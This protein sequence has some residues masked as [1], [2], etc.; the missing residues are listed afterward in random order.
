[1]GLQAAKRAEEW[2]T[3]RECA[4]KY[5]ALHKP[6]W[7]NP[8]HAE[9]WTSTLTTYAYPVFGN[10]PV[11]AIDT[12][13]VLKVVE[14]IWATKNET[15]NRVRN[16]IELILDW[17][18]VRNYRSGDNPARW[19]GHLE[20]ALPARNKVRKRQNMASLSY[21]EIGAFMVELRK[22]ESVSAL[23]LEFTI[24]TAAR[25]DETIGTPGARST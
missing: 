18:K 21:R 15:A 22:R 10:Q 13:L 4:E 9:Q 8:K 19:K 1:V 6:T 17:A 14:P 11:K 20:N 7:R 2:A 12:T 24:L 23:A 5:I 25:T 3:F 16:R